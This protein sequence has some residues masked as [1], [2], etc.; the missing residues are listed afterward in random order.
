MI[1]NDEKDTMKTAWCDHWFCN[2]MVYE[3][4][5]ASNQISFDKVKIIKWLIIQWEPLSVITMGQKE[6]DN[7]N[8]MITITGSFS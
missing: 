2:Q 5:L 1:S 6:T 3:I 7:I 8:P 4:K